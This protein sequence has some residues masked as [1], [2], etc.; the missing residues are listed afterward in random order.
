MPFASPSLVKSRECKPASLY[1]LTK[2]KFEEN[3]VLGGWDLPYRFLGT[4]ITGIENTVP[5]VNGLTAWIDN[6]EHVCKVEFYTEEYTDHQFGIYDILGREVIT[7]EY[8]LH[9]GKN[10]FPIQNLEKILPRISSVVTSPVISP[11]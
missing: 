9:P 3:K 4:T 8:H 10:Y 6:T 1:S 2:V 7:A 11:R 5:Q